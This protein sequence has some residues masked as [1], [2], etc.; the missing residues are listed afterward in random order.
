MLITALDK[1]LLLH[2][3]VPVTLFCAVA[4]GKPLEAK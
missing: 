3:T 4:T 1:G 2:K